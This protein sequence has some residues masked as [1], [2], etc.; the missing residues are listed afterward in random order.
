MSNPHGPISKPRPTEGGAYP[1]LNEVYKDPTL[2]ARLPL[3]TILRLRRQAIVVVADLDA[4]LIIAV[5]H[6]ASDDVQLGGDAQASPS[7]L[8]VSEAANALRFSRGHTY[9]LIRTGVLGAVRS[10]RAVRIPPDALA[11]W[12]ARHTTRR[13]DD[14]DSVSLSSSRERRADQTHPAG[15]GADT[16]AVRRPRRRPQGNRGQVGDGRPGNAGSSRPTDH[17]LGARPQSSTE[18]PFKVST[19]K[20]AKAEE[21]AEG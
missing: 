7:L 5:T 3:S 12:Q 8:T 9:E 10:G 1:S 11:A 2:L 16:A 17:A 21:A 20:T 14:A 19:S 15:T 6:T 4:A 13:L 18:T